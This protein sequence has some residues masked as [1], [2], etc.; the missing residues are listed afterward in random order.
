VTRAEVRSEENRVETRSEANGAELGTEE[1]SSAK[2][3]K[4]TG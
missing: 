2:N 1:T 4:T 3:K